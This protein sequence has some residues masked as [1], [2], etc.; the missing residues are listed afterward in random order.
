L[1]MNQYAWWPITFGINGSYEFCGPLDGIMF[2]GEHWGS[3]VGICLWFVGSER[4]LSAPSL[5]CYQLQILSSAFCHCA[6]YLE[7]R[8][9]LYNTYVKYG[10]A[11]KCRRKFRHKFRNK[12]FPSR[13]TIHNLVKFSFMFT[14]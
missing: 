7:K 4:H 8:V 13:Q 10:S 1:Q 3:C 2:Y 12:R 14:D 11:R 5:I 6:V 9:F